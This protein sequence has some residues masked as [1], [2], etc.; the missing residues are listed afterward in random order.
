MAWLYDIV[1]IISWQ[2]GQPFLKG[3]RMQQ[4]KGDKLFLHK[5]KVA[6]Q[7]FQF[8]KSLH[9]DLNNYMI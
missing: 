9:P 4:T 1:F 6:V 8:S 2:A 5:G 7:S 3:L